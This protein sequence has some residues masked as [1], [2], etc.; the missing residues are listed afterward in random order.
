MKSQYWLSY[1][2]RSNCFRFEPATT[3]H[4]KRQEVC[5]E[6]S[7]R[8]DWEPTSV[9]ADV[10]NW[11]ELQNFESASWKLL[12]SLEVRETRCSWKPMFVK[13]DFRETRCSWFHSF[14]MVH[15][16]TFSC[17][18]WLIAKNRDETT[19]GKSRS[20]SL[21]LLCWSLSSDSASICHYICLIAVVYCAMR[22]SSHD[23]LCSVL[24]K[25]FCISLK[26]N[27]CAVYAFRR[28]FVS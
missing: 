18:S 10:P 4:G 25:C 9:V 2:K 17:L 27:I 1:C 11:G 26:V 5:C 23:V 22:L 16:N 12:Y 13:S 14:V 20:P 24:P 6:P 8:S 19:T 15:T 21:L 28:S 3:R 7:G